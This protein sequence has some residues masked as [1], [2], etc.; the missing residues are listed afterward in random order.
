MY[1]RYIFLIPKRLLK[2]IACLRPGSWINR[3]VYR[4]IAVAAYSLQISRPCFGR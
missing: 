4:D 2:Q 3:H 1:I